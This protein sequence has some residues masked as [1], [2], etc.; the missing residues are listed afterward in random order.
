M[1]GEVF[2]VDF[3]HSQKI[4]FVKGDLFDL[5][6]LNWHS[7]GDGDDESEDYSLPTSTSGKTDVS[8]TASESQQTG[9]KTT[10]T[11]TYDRRLGSS[12]DASIME[13]LNTSSIAEEIGS[14]KTQSKRYVC[15]YCDDNATLN[16]IC[17]SL[18]KRIRPPCMVTGRRLSPQISFQLT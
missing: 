16:P 7:Q 4:F 3:T 6:S 18:A 13:E 12:S 1:P 9:T 5:T 17:T 10:P 11:T 2:K 15:L 8:R 14:E